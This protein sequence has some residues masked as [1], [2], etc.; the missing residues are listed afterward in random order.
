MLFKRDKVIVG[1][2]AAVYGMNH[3]SKPFTVL[4][5]AGDRYVAEWNLTTGEQEPLAVK[6]EQSVFSVC[7]L[8]GE[9]L[10]VAGS[11]NGGLHVIDLKEKKELHHFTVHTKGI[12]DFY[13]DRK[14]KQLMAL[15][16]DGVLTVWS[17]PSFDLL[18]KI[19]LSSEKLRQ[20]AVS[21]DHGLMAITCGDGTVR[22]L[23]P[24]F[25]SEI[26]SIIAHKQGATSVAWH[27]FKPVLFT[28]GRDA[29]LNA[30]N[31]R[32]QYNNLLSLPAHNYA[33]YSI[34]FDESE[35]YMATASRDKTI[36][37]WDSHSIDL[38]QRIDVK[39]GGHTHSINKLLW[40]GS[41]L[42]SCGDDRK[43]IVWKK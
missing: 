27:P 11:G 22:L 14:G 17:V 26:R 19:P 16:G 32:E 42:V 3:G 2:T 39:Q 37:I 34:V 33:I 8:E 30:W 1:H 31:A 5:A 23:E 18:R 25:F 41:D 40:S 20:I 12:Y 15:G 6:F 21:K 36:K 35:N 43:I 7:Y 29:M 13:F 28:G 38:L 9:D 4:S 24:D 10:V